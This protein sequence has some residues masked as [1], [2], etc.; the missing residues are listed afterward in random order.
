[1]YSETFLKT[2][3]NYKKPNE[4]IK[5]N[6]RPYELPR[7]HSH[8]VRINLSEK[9]FGRTSS[10]NPCDA[11][12]YLLAHLLLRHISSDFILMTIW[13]GHYS[14]DSSALLLWV[15]CSKEISQPLSSSI[16]FFQYDFFVRHNKISSRNSIAVAA[17][18]VNAE[19]AK[20]N[21]SFDRIFKSIN[22]CRITFQI[23]CQ[24]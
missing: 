18:R 23:E 24:L 7:S 1:V 12:G 3:R 22:L 20:K 21:C 9:T 5:R 11:L 19:F 8:T 2:Q 16:V 14:V 13:D 17:D 15:V 10:T 6:N 4:I